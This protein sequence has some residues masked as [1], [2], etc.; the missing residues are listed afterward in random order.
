[1]RVYVF[2]ED[3]S[4]LDLLMLYLK[5]Q[6]HQAQGFSSGYNCPLYLLE[7][8]ECPA[9]KPCADAVLVN[10]RIPN[11]ESIQVLLDQD[12]KG[13]KLP[14]SNKA[15]MSASFNVDQEEHIRQHGFSVLKKPFRLTA[16]TSWLKECA[17]RL[18]NHGR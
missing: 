14:K 10:T 12:R 2:E 4:I 7:E 8:C 9:S 18:E 5:G 6:G 1:M 17:V 13:C 11:A 3:P 15:V 16:I